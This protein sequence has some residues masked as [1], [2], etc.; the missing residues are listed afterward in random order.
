MLRSSLIMTALVASLMMCTVHAADQHFTE[1]SLEY[2]H[3]QHPD[4]IRPHRGQLNVVGSS[5]VEK[6]PEIAYM[7][8][9]A[10]AAEQDA[11]LAESKVN[12]MVERLNVFLT[13]AAEKNISIT[14]DSI[15][16]RPKYH[17]NRDT[18]R[19]EFDSFEAYR[20]VRIGVKDFSLIGDLIKEALSKANISRVNGI[21]YDLLDRESALKE[22]DAKAV[23]DAKEKASRLAEGFNCSVDE[24]PVSVTYGHV[25]FNGI[26]PFMGAKMAMMDQ[27]DGAAE[28]A[29]SASAS[30]NYSPEKIK[31]T[32]TVYVTFD[33]KSLKDKSK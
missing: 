2:R 16:I 17:Y 32:S 10:Y 8:F 5:Y 20:N 27:V 28:N 15:N 31:V 24:V 9:T 19:Q 3:V 25:P 23:A 33:L 30:S 4:R 29:V 11:A 26:H 14:S 1:Q 21:T 18:Q 6:T 13:V 7:S 22:A 12:E